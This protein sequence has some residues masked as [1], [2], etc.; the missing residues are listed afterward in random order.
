MVDGSLTKSPCSRVC[1]LALALCCVLAVGVLFSG[2]RA[3]AQDATETPSPAE[4]CSGPVSLP[5]TSGVPRIDSLSVCGVSE[6]DATLHASINPN[7]LETTYEF[8]REYA[9]CQGTGVQCESIAVGPVGQG[10]IPVGDSDQTVT[11]ELSDLQPNYSYTYW[12]VATSSAGKAE[13]SHETFTAQPLAPVIESESVSNITEHD[14]TL[15]A[16]I[17][18]NGGYTGYEFQIDTNGSYNFARPSCPFEWP[19]NSRCEPIGT[20]EPLVAGLVEPQAAYIAAG[21]GGQSVSLDLASVGTTL[22]PATT[23]HYRVRVTNDGHGIIAGPDQTF[24]TPA[25]QSASGGTQGA[26]S[27]DTT[28]AASA[29]ASDPM[30]ALQKNTLKP[31]VLT[32]TQRLV[33]ALKACAKKPKDRHAKCER[34]ARYEYAATA[35]ETGK[36]ASERN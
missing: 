6:H 10:T 12:V 20:V 26:G 9:V 29:T 4:S 3:L 1:R 32:S 31:K 22:Q 27:G 14:A 21:A 28:Q 35:R 23:Y 2:A 13:S 17:D 15:E 18:P 24:T 11:T 16:Q 34:Q 36:Q 5:P 8:W 33:K 25:E 7:S 30:T 19:G